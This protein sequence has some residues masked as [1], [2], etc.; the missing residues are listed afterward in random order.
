MIFIFKASIF[1]CRHVWNLC[2]NI[3]DGY[4]SVGWRTPLGFFRQS[5]C[6]V[7]IDICLVIYKF[8]ICGIMKLRKSEIV[9]LLACA[10]GE[11]F[12]KGGSE[13]FLSLPGGGVVPRHIICNFI[14]WFEEIWSLGRPLNPKTPTQPNPTPFF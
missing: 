7:S 6:A 11:N 3:P 9:R 12:P 5:V 4:V 13:S 14:I 10:D 2:H 8:V 1:V